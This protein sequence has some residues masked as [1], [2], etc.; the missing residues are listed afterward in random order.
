MTRVL[1]VLL[2]A[3]GLAAGCGSS[4]PT[5]P[6]AATSVFSA[7]L[8]PGNETPA[9][10]NADVSGSGSVTI[11]LHLTK[12]ASGTITAATAD[13][14]VSLT[15]FPAN[16]TL[17]GAH[18]HQAVA[19]VSGA[20]VVST[21]LANGEVVLANGSGSFTKNSVNVPADVAQ[22]MINN[23]AGYYFNVHSTLNP[24]G[25]ARGQLT[26]TQ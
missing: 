26:K 11:T 16:T 6:S 18:I 22:G 15:G 3:A 2:V 21:G 4:T 10:T 12:D 8:L 7:Q 19:G 14:Q 24:T 5:M 17:T 9:V 1:V 20:I 25:C 23:P 13:F